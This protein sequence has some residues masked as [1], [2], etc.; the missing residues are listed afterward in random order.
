M[1]SFI[2]VCSTSSWDNSSSTSD[3]PPIRDDELGSPPLLLAPPLRLLG[4]I[5]SISSIISFFIW[6]MRSWGRGSRF[7]CF[8]KIF[9]CTIMSSF[10]WFCALECSS[11]LFW[12]WV[13]TYSVILVIL[14]ISWSIFVP[15]FCLSYLNILTVHSLN[16]MFRLLPVFS[17][18]AAEAIYAVFFFLPAM[19][20]S[21]DGFCVWAKF[22]C[23]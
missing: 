17:T 7:T 1:R 15:M 18:V 6:S 23:C 12:S 16:V 13:L 20:L 21:L 19:G 4:L 9:S 3:A 8:V 2:E 22:C 11:R 14:A 10:K 5:F